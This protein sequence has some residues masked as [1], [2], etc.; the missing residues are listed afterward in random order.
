MTTAMLPGGAWL[1]SFG[2][3]QA[4]APRLICFPHAGGSASY[5][6]NISR[7]LAPDI[8]VLAVQYPGRQDRITERPPGSLAELADRVS[9]VLAPQPCGRASFFGHSMGS[10]LAFEVARRTA[11][12]PSGGPLVLFASGYPAPS[13]IRGGSVH[14]RNDAGLV[15]ELRALGGIDERWL[16]DPDVLATILPPLRA[17]YRLIETH[18]RTAERLSDV[19]VAVFIGDRDP[20]TTVAEAEAW[21]EATSGPFRLRVLAGGH[22]YLDEHLST[23][24]QDIRATIERITNGS[25][26]QQDKA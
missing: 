23:V 2:V 15:Q 6:Y 19:P 11:S 16:V 13:R 26:E 24:A 7:M 25:V 1:R 22:F 14:Q 4:D 5:F 20:H 18:P 10:V 12:W 9:A 8:E 21:R 17:D 3:A